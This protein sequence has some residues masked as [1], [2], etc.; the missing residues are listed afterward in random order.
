M[1]AQDRLSRAVDE[2]ADALGTLLDRSLHGDGQ[3]LE[4]LVALLRTR[5]YTSIID[6]LHR[7]RT[8]ASTQTIED[9][10]QDSILRLVEK[11]KSGELRDLPDS[12]RADVL[13]YFFRL[14]DRRIADLRRPRLSPALARDK[15]EL[16]TDLI[17]RNAVIPGEN[18][19]TERHRALLES[20][21]LR[22]GPEEREI[23]EEYLK[24]ASQKE[25]A[26]KVGKKPS[27][28]NNLI[29]RLKERL[30]LDIAPRS[31]TARLNYEAERSSERKKPSREE[32]KKAVEQL[33]LELAQVI[34]AIHYEKRT[35]ESLARDLGSHGDRKV[36][37][38]LKQAYRVLGAK[39]RADFP[40]AFDESQV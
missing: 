22:L 2:R 12:S 24:G 37:S 14:C 35:F 32:V 5:H 4:V 23:L 39:L 9:A 29:A 19:T 36:A 15:E 18:K 11:V 7:T 21:V 28:I 17:D 1:S 25:I 40:R 10:F 27:D 16:P 6:R 20:A 26:E 8:Q 34:Q 3:A 33:P 30:L 13:T 31:Q 38:R